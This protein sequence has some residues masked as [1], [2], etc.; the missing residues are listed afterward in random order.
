MHASYIRLKTITMRSGRDELKGKFAPGSK[1]DAFL[2]C[3]GFGGSMYEPEEN[4]VMT[5][6]ASL[7][8]TVLLVSHRTGNPND[9]IFQE[10]VRQLVDAVTYLKDV[11]GAK[12]VHL[13]GISMGGANVVSTVAIDDRIS[14]VA[15]SSGISD[16]RLWLKERQGENFD[17]L[18]ETATRIET[19]QIM[20]RRSSGRLFE[21]TDLLRIPVSDASE[22]KVKGRTT[23]VSAR[24][25]RSLLTYR[26]ILSVRG[27]ADK[28]V[29]FFH[30]TGDQLVSHEHSVAMYTSAKTKKYKLLINGGDHGMIL[31][32][33]VR[34]KILSLYLRELKKNSLLDST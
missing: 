32:D 13:F 1:E 6:L 22:P 17:R 15:S 33:L 4:S 24:T 19:L 25:I 28:P 11:V 23:K 9:L 7:G 21:V 31:E 3:H 29:F 10:Q 2:V 20:G 30:G 34:E 16:C 8:Y 27:I 5:D 18:V 12:R 14:S 26:P